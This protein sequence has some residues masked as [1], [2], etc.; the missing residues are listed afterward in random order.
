LYYAKGIEWLIFLRDEMGYDDLI[1]INDNVILTSTNIHIFG[2]KILQKEKLNIMD[3]PNPH[4][5]LL[6]DN[7]ADLT[8][9]SDRY[10]YVNTNGNVDNLVNWKKVS[11]NYGGIEFANYHKIM[12][13]MQEMDS[14][15]ARLNRYNVFTS[16]DV[17]GGC[18]WNVP[19]IEVIPIESKMN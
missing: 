2:I 12:K 5:I 14:Y 15:D 11:K 18:L 10:N 3:V 19:D 9:F 1:E 8:E 13:E 16:F 4:K 6:I 7:F 17:N